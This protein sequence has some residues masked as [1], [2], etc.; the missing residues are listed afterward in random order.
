MCCCYHDKW[1]KNYSAL[2]DGVIPRIL[3]IPGI[4]FSVETLRLWV[5]G[6][7]TGLRT[8]WLLMQIHELQVQGKR[9]WDHPLSTSITHYAP[10]PVRHNQLTFH[11][12]LFY[13]YN[14]GEIENSNKHIH[15]LWNGTGR[16]RRWL[17]FTGHLANKK[18]CHNCGRFFQSSWPQSNTSVMCIIWAVV[19]E[20]HVLV[21]V[22]DH[23]FNAIAD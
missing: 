9:K 12:H 4:P 22:Q 21:Q 14:T 5:S 3:K 18:L 7:E 17:C 6:W 19:P 1:A 15:K 11:F 2:L 20:T 8:C 16:F 10:I 13:K 23:C